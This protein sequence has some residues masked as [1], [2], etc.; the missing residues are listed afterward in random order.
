[1][2]SYRFIASGDWPPSRH[3]FRLL[4][5]P[6]PAVNPVLILQRDPPSRFP[7]PVQATALAPT[8]INAYR[9]PHEIDGILQGRFSRPTEVARLTCLAW[10]SSTLPQTSDSDLPPSPTY[11]PRR[12]PA[13]FSLEN[14]GEPPRSA[15][16]CLV[17]RPDSRLRGACGPS[18]RL[19]DHPPPP[20]HAAAATNLA[21]RRHDSR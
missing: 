19:R 1:M 8:P 2:R 9:S 12:R 13:P 15:Q 6:S 7:A 14:R 3:P 18:R 5:C 11:L 21:P 17:R 4:S 10:G 16:H 20:E